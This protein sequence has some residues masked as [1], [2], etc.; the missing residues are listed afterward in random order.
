LDCS[1]PQL[2]KRAR[3]KEQH[4]PL[5]PTPHN[6]DNTTTGSAFEGLAIEEL[7]LTALPVL[8]AAEKGLATGRHTELSALRKALLEW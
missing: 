2:P 5:A 3:P 7:A 8:R 1:E 4:I 6:N